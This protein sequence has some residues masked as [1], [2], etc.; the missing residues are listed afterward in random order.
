MQKLILQKIQENDM[1]AEQQNRG[2]VVDL[3]GQI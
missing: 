1:V 2:A 3:Q